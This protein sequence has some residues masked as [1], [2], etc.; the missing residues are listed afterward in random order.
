MTTIFIGSDHA[1]FEFKNYL[2]KKL[3]KYKIVDCGTNS[4]NSCDYSD[5]ANLVS[6]KVSNDTTAF[7]I[8]ICGT[9]IG[10]SIA[11]NK[12]SKNIRCSL[13]YNKFMAKM[14]RNHNNANIISIGVRNENQLRN[15]DDLVDIIEVF[16]ISKFSN[17]ERHIRRLSKIK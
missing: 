4:D 6:E 17:Q 13:C 2:I 10:M 8:L 7:G 9:G 1:G 15:F 14:A 3:L 12:Y 11:A 16:L 5:I